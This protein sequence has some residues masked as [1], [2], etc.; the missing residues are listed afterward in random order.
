M[1]A[2]GSHIDDPTLKN[3]FFGAVRLTKIAD[4]DRYGYSGYG[5]GFDR[6]LAISFPGDMSSSVHVDSN[7][8]HIFILGRGL[9]QGL[10]HTLTAEKYIRLILQWHKQSFA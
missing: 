10:E 7:K 2:S 8:K 6:K 5:V 4:I 3:C 9:T 1:G